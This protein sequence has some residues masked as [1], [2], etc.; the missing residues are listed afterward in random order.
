MPLRHAR[1]TLPATST[2][3][4]PAVVPAT[5][6]ARPRTPQQPATLSKQQ[7][8][9]QSPVAS[10]PRVAREWLTS[11]TRRWPAQP[12]YPQARKPA[13]HATTS[14]A[15]TAIA[16]AQAGTGT[17]AIAEGIT[18]TAG[19]STITTPTTTAIVSQLRQQGRQLW[20]AMLAADTA[21][22]TGRT[23]E[24]QHPR[25]RMPSKPRMA[26]PMVMPTVP[27][28]R[29]PLNLGM[30]VITLKWSRRRSHMH[31][32]DVWRACRKREPSELTAVLG[33]EELDREHN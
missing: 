1:A 7:V 9:A 20:Q 2:G 17:G 25:M 32:H 31:I 16:A 6:V 5:L 18:P 13:R 4:L 15:G 24:R 10:M 26:L 3:A 22:Q 30:I 29:L 8:P 23:T 33:L 21:T 11:T 27:V 19:G 14:M 28:A 12:E